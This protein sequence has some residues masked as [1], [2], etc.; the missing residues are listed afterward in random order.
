M[1]NPALNRLP[2]H[3]KK[4]IVDQRYQDYTPIDHSVWR[5][6]M[7]QSLRFLSKH[8]HSS[9]VEGLKKTGINTEYI[10][11]VNEMNQILADIGWGAV[12]VDGFIPPN[13]FMEFQAYNVLVIA[14]DIRHINHI[15]YTPAPDIVHEAAGHAPI[16]ANPEYAEYLRLF[17]EIGS[18]ALS[19]KKDIELYE[20][21]RK[22]SILKESPQS[23]QKE[24]D[25]AE[26]EVHHLQNNL[27][28]LS[29]MAK[30]RNLHWW[31]VEYGLIGDQN[32][33]Q[34]YGAGLLSSIGESMACLQPQV[35]KLPYTTSA[36]EFSF[37]ITTQQPQLFV[38]PDFSHLTMVLN[39]FADSMALRKGGTKG[40]EQA[41]ESEAFATVE[42]DSGVQI[43]G[44]FSRLIKDKEGKVIFIK[45]AGPSLLC[46][47]DQLL[48]GHGTEYH[49]HGYSTPVG[50]IKGF[51]KPLQ[52]YR[53]SELKKLGIE[54]GKKCTFSF[55]GG[56]EVEGNVH[57]FRK[58]KY[59]KTLLIALSDCT[60]TYQ[61]ETLF[62]PE[63]GIYDM[64]VG[65]EVK[66]VFAGSADKDEYDSDAYVSPTTT[67]RITNHA[68][69]LLALYQKVR[70][71]R[72]KGCSEKEN[73]LQEVFLEIKNRFSFDWLL[74]LE[75]LELLDKK[76][77]L[78]VGVKKYLE[79]KCNQDEHRN[80]ILN[81][82]NAIS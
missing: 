7:R 55:E 64:A 65:E 3:L 4:Y 62:M 75:I 6:I 68:P 48:I 79:E 43:S 71:I 78:S 5:Y 28:T 46:E 35:K 47:Q 19:S 41:I 45:T 77:S 51:T 38:T 58:N 67:Q 24:I 81:G 57:S 2:Q 69:E 50:K 29:E 37:D 30:I 40:V 76:S 26:Q 25:K 70:D 13:A 61:D 1:N 73:E 17:G 66:S 52:D 16:I 33:P 32:S 11:N 23:T 22:L 9:Y 12:C 56:I 53:L 34:L 59:G 80:L 54:T 27:G 39:E 18:K 60:V 14:A 42:L 44:V 63:W 8:A 15:E 20:A 21:I 82:L 72:E 36:A 10:P 49:S 74:S 31:T